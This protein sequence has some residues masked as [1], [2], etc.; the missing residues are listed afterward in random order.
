MGYFIECDYQKAMGNES[1]IWVGY[2]GLKFDPFNVLQDKK[3]SFQ[4][5]I[6]MN[7]AN[8]YSKYDQ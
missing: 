7:D 6:A 1:F 2:S 5:F 3:M 8:M 4:T